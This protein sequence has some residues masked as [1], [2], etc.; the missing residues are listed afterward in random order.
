MVW[1]LHYSFMGGVDIEFSKNVTDFTKTITKF[2]NYIQCFA[3]DNKQ[4][5]LNN[6][7]QEFYNRNDEFYEGFFFAIN[8]EF[9]SVCLN[10]SLYLK[11]N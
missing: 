6:F 1:V 11:E 4:L 10:K 2:Q 7:I 9:I 3:N 8:D 5:E